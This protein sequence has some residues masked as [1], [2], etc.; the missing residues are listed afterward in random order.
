MRWGSVWWYSGDGSAEQ[1]EAERDYQ[2]RD[3]T[4]VFEL[5]C[6][7][8]REARWKGYD[9][10]NIGGVAMVVTPDRLESEAFFTRTYYADWLKWIEDN[11]DKNSH[12]ESLARWLSSESAAMKEAVSN[13]A[14]SGGSREDDQLEILDIGCGFGR[15]LVDLLEGHSDWR[16]VGIDIN[17]SMVGQANGLAKR[18]NVHRQVS[19]I[20]DDVA[21]LESCTES[22]IDFAICMTNTLGNLTKDKQNALVRNLRKILKPGGRAFFSAYADS[23]TEARV[24]TYKAIGLDVEQDAQ[25]KMIIASQGLE[26]E[27]FSGN[28]LRRLLVDN[29]LR[30][31]GP[32][33][34]IQPIGIWAVAERPVSTGSKDAG[35]AATR[36]ADA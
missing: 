2:V 7:H 32:V 11:A 24:I 16:G 27:T 29:D 22:E 5:I 21:V 17:P 19:F 8:A 23:S 35:D 31:V 28:D 14:S 1:W 13:Y 10:S 6:S 20:V 30:I 12:A 36:M 15:H 34:E 4:E 18:Q 3:A 26:S 9:A 25:R 33:E